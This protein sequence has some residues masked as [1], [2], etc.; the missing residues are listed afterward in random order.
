MRA[1]LSPHQHLLL[2]LIWCRS[3]S[4]SCKAA[5]NK[6]CRKAVLLYDD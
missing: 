4:Q 5:L 1:G 2:T 6:S 3:S